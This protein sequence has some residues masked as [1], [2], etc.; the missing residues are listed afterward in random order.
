[1]KL[2]NDSLRN[3]RLLSKPYRKDVLARTLRE[4]FDA[5]IGESRDVPAM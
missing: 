5:V 3:L 4:A 2:T 1:M